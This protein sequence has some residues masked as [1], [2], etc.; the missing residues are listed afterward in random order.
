MGGFVKVETGI[1]EKTINIGPCEKVKIFGEEFW[2]EYS[3]H[4]KKQKT[5][6][7]LIYP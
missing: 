7:G 1:T 5:V 4:S 3:D 2:G 6:V